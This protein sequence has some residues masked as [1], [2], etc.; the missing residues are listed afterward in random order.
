MTS[1]TVALTDAAEQF[2]KLSP[3]G[4]LSLPFV[5]VLDEAANVCRWRELPD[6]YSHYG[7]RS[8]CLMTI[9]QSWSQGVEVWGRDGMRKLW[10]AANV[11]VYGGG[12][13]EVEFLKELS[14]LIGDFELQHRLHHA[15]PRPRRRPLHQLLQPP[16]ADPRRL[17]PRIAAQGPPGRVRLGRPPD[18]RPARPLD[19]RPARAAVRASI[20]A[21]TRAHTASP[22]PALRLARRRRAPAPATPL[23][24]LVSALGEWDEPAPPRARRR[25]QPG[26]RAPPPPLY[27]AHLEDFVGDYLVQVYRRSLSG[28]STAWCPEWWRH[29]EACSAWRRCGAPGSTC[30]STPPPAC[31][32]GSETTPTTTWPSCC[33]QTARSRAAGSTVTASTRS[34]RCRWPRRPRPC[35]TSP[36]PTTPVRSER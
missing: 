11:K 25:Q 26:R 34:S 14:S 18:P 19:G 32:C 22:S 35:A 28:P 33:P 24:A 8:I 5:G 36:P 10:S 23:G 1:L 13:S 7:S 2:A 17:R 9:L 16:R 20:E 6:L 29:P 4:R 31:R 27:Y 12:V 3:R 30:A 15:L 21:S